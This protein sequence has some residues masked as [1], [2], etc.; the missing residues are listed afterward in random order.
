M[1]ARG[2]I[3]FALDYQKGGTP[4]TG[5]FVA[6]P[7]PGLVPERPIIPDPSQILEFGWR[8]TSCRCRNSC[9]SGACPCV[10][11]GDFFPPGSTLPGPPPVCYADPPIAVGYEFTADPTSLPFASVVIPTPL[12]RGDADFS[13][14]A[15]G[16]SFPLQAGESFSFLAAGFTGGVR[17]FRIMDIDVAETLATTDATAFVTGLTWLGPRD[18]ATGFVMAPVAFDTDDDDVD[19]VMNSADNCP[20]TQ[21]TDQAD[22]NGNGLGDVCDSS[23]APG[24]A[25]DLLVTSYDTIAGTLGLS[26]APACESST[27]D[28]HFGPL[29][30]VSNYVWSGADCDI[31]A[32]GRYGGFNPGTGSYFFIVV[33]G[34]GAEEGPY[35]TDAHGVPRPP[36]AGG[37]C[38]RSQTATSSCP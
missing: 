13:V 32:T 21:N 19:G 16:M 1:N 18:G 20:A 4:Y 11:D 25:S 12:P 8:I 10:P 28:I 6:D 38:G 23:A 3:A 15:G 9:S 24:E 2:R 33:G 5:L 30:Q 35:G 26:Y 17:S 22:S 37:T 14:E 7:Q 27:H 31:G 34:A 29:D 36:H